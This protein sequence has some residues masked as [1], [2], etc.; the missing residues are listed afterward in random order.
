[1]NMFEVNLTTVVNMRNAINQFNKFKWLYF[2]SLC[3][4]GA[5][6]DLNLLKQI[7]FRVKK[8][9]KFFFPQ[10]TEVLLAN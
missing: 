7:H 5:V 9:F 6:F 2:L 3:R 8:S 10:N 4:V 1:M